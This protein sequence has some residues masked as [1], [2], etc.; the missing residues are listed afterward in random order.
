MNE[1]IMNPRQRFLRALIIMFSIVVAGVIGYMIIE[2][3]SFFDALYMTVITL[4]T[5]GYDEVNHLSQAGRIFSIV[6]IVGGV[7]GMLYTMTTIVQ[8]FVEGQMGNIFGR[9]RMQ[10]KISKL[11]DHIIVCGYRRVGREV[12]HVFE[13][14]GI[15]FVVV[16]IQSEAIEE[17]TNDGCLY[18]QGNATSDEVLTKAGIHQARA[19]VAALGSDV[20][21]VYIIL[22][23]K[24]IR[25][26]IFI[27]A[28]TSAEESRSKLMRAGADRVI[29]PHRIGGRRMALLTLRPLVVDFIDTTMHSRHGEMML[30]NIKVGEGSPVAGV[31]VKEGLTCCGAAGILA[32]RKEN[33]NLIANPQDGMLLEFGD[34]LVVIGTR[35]QLRILEGGA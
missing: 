30:E 28:R 17:A 11:K 23:A 26:D 4:S 24:G 27:V 33:G 9:R 2:K 25:P 21:N 31:T 22:S 1:K 18:I 19:L 5:V 10:E 20:E 16:D 34:E 32:V 15:P 12:A 13:D 35:E 3:W 29:S 14:E 8:Y 7:G 6:L